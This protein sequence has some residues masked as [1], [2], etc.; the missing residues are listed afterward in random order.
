[1]EIIQTIATLLPLSLT[2]GINLYATVLMTGL[3]IRFQWIGGIPHSLDLLSSWPILIVTGV[4]FIIEFGAGIIPGFDVAWDVLH[5]LVRPLGMAG[6]GLL[7]LGEASPMMVILI[8]LMVG[9]I[10]AVAHGGK[11]GGRVAMN[12]LSPYENMT[13]IG[14]GIGENVFSIILTLFALKYP[15]IASAI[16]IVVLV[17]IIIIT[18]QLM[19]WSF[20]TVSSVF[21][22]I[23]SFFS[24]KAVSDTLPT[25]YWQTAAHRVPEMA[26][27]CH[28]HG[29]K[30][31]N[32]RSGYVA[33]Y[34]PNLVFIYKAFFSTRLWQVNTGQLLAG[35]LEARSLMDVI[36][37]HYI[38]QEN[39]KKVI[40]FVFQKD[41]SL[42]A[43][44]LLEALKKSRDEQREKRKFMPT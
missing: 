23:K 7:F 30:G 21:A 24:K 31:A 15:Y 20:F 25:E 2:S 16:A 17:L 26:V 36:G 38:D 40:R 12:I 11:T 41:R 35:H 13:N 37:L 39:K 33:K 28:A 34:G 10:S 3:C 18:P 42:L 5:G 8:V 9:S 6:I 29:I 19:R 43:K 44:S 1:M 27:K 14:M 4:F 22:K 32:G